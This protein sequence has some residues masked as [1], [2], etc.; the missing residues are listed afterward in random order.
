MKHEGLG[1]EPDTWVQIS[2]WAF[3]GCMTACEYPA[4]SSPVFSPVP[5]TLVVLRE[6][7]GQ[8]YAPVLSCVSKSPSSI[9]TV[10]SGKI[11]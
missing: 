9:L 5:A 10:G 8:A 11:T 1:A 3:A 4:S 7:V 2:A 6:A